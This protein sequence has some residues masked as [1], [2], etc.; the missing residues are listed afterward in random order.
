MGEIV[1]SRE[2]YAEPQR[3][4]DAC[5]SIDLH[6]RLARPIGGQALGGR[7]TGLSEQ[8]DATHWSARFFGMKFRLET[9]ITLADPPWALDE[10]MTRGLFRQFGHR[11]RIRSLDGRSLLTDRFYFQCPAGWLGQLVARWILLPRLRRAQEVRMD[12]LKLFCESGE[13]E[14]G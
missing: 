1:S 6:V 10:T 11:Y 9:T 13:A 7:T 2:I 3:V 4:Y 8:G 14:I 12:G 5:R